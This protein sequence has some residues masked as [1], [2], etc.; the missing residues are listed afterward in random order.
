MLYPSIKFFELIYFSGD[1]EWAL[2]LAGAEG[3]AA[4]GIQTTGMTSEV[5]EQP[6][7]TAE[8]IEAAGE[9][10]DKVQGQPQNAGKFKSSIAGKCGI[11]H[12][13]FA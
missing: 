6:H 8:L 12:I 2:I 1:H 9:E 13:L 7:S 4:A 5:K 10:Q 11:A 3:T